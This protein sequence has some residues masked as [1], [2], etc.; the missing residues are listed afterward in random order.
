ML[1]SSVRC[2]HTTSSVYFR[3]LAPR[4]TCSCTRRS[5]CGRRSPTSARSAQRHLPTLRICRSIPAF[6]WALSHIAARYASASLRNCR[7][8]SS[9]YAPT[10]ATS[11]T[12]A[13]IPAARRPSPSCPICSRTRAAIRR[14]NRSSATRATSVFRTNPH[15]WNT[16]PSTK[17]PSI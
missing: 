1:I 5:T 9:T 14:T 3:Y 16:Y 7:T 6:I 13:D 2:S 15:C 8:C 17:S 10:R 12:N 4:R 11:R